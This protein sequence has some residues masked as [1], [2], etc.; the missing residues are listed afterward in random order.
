MS[1][2]TSEQTTSATA[3]RPFT[4][5]VLQAEID[6]LRARLTATRW[7]DK[8]TVD[9]RS[10]GVQLAKLRPLVEYWGTG[11]DWRKVEAQTQRVAAVHDRDRRAE[12]SV[13]AYPLTNPTDHGG[14]A[15][16][17]FHSSCR[18]C[19][20]TASQASRRRPAGTRPTWRERPTSSCSG[21]AT[22]GMSPREV[23][24]ARSSR[25]CLRSRRPR[26][27][28]ASTSICP[29]LCRRT[30]SGTFATSIARP[31]S[32]RIARRSLTTRCS[33]LPRR[34]RLRGNDEIRAR[35]RSATP[36]RTRRS[37]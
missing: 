7:P 23:T 16:H 15:E 30:S 4:V 26:G 19:P 17:A 21:S 28:W 25:S 9:D 5:E 8:E 32:C 22:R 36:W 31:L 10:Q 29:G 34:L 12:Y 2:M 20:A 18:R 14:R 37:R 6:A 1:V 35:R 3:I 27:C 13:R 24:G 33:L 11:Y